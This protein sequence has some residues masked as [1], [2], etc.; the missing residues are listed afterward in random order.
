MPPGSAPLTGI[1]TLHPNN[2]KNAPPTI[3]Y[4]P[5]EQHYLN[6]RKQRLI[7]ARDSRD[8]ARDERDGMP[9]LAYFDILKK[10]DD[11]FVAPRKNKQDTSINLGTIRDKDTSLI[12]YAM[13][14][15]FEPIAIV[16][17]DDGDMFEELAETGEDLVRKSL[18]LDDWRD[19]QKLIY[20][21]MVAFGTALVEDIYVQRWVIDKT[22][23]NG[24]KAGMGSDKAEWEQRMRLQYDGCQAKLWDQR[25]CYP[26]DI[27]KFFMNGPQG[28]PYFFTVEYESYD[29]VKQLYGNWD[30]WQFVPNFVV[31]TPEIS[32]PLV[33][34]PWWTLRPVSMNYCEIIRYYD[35]IANEFAITINGVDMLPLMKRESVDSFA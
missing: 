25:K 6:F 22:L 18:I 28:Q 7:S 19:K 4:T 32:S 12:E 23:K 33:F 16:H 14:H 13:A 31:A 10:A 24:Y 20:R 26:G 29:V 8:A 9:Y 21:S 34:T 3:S 1:W 17:D 35:P 11:Q 30:R 15:D 27:R 5:E 2:E